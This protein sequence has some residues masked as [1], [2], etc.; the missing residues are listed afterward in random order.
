MGVNFSSL[1]VV[2]RGESK[3]TAAIEEYLRRKG[4]QDDAHA[5]MALTTAIITST[6]YLEQ[7]LNALMA[8]VGATVVNDPA[9]E[10]LEQLRSGVYDD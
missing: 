1:P 2:D 9:D 3:V 6:A 8:A 5:I 10:L 4:E 7:R